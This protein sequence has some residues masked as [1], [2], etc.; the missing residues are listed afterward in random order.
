MTIVRKPSD[1][2]DLVIE[3]LESHPDFFT[4]QPELLKQLDIPHDL[5]V[6]IPSLIEYQVKQLRQQDS[7]LKDK[8]KYFQ[9]RHQSVLQ[10]SDVIQEQQNIILE[11]DSIE[12]LYD[13]FYQFLNQYYSVNYLLY[14][15]FVNKRT[16]EDYRGLRFR[17]SN[18][19]V[20][21]LFTSLFNHN[22]PLCDCLQDDYLEFLFG[23]KASTIRSTA[24]FPVQNVKND[25]PIGLMITASRNVDQFEQGLSLNL[26]NQLKSLFIHQLFRIIWN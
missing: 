2:L 19:K 24:V 22:K 18:S 14:F 25:G 12:K 21:N 17:K 16:Y 3:Y 10:L 8:L 20:Q 23:K 6:N 5:G 15:V 11:C 9:Q 26:L 1:N 13:S 4:H 7:I